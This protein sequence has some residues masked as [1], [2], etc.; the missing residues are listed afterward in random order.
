MR[1]SVAGALLALALSVTAL[2]LSPAGGTPAR[3]KSASPGC[4]AAAVAPA[5]VTVTALAY[6]TA[7]RAY[8]LAAPAVDDPS[9]PLP[10]ILNFHGLTSNAVQQAV[11]SQL[12]DKGPAHGYVVVTPEGS[13]PA[14]FWNILP[15]LPDPDDVGFSEALI[16]TVGEHLCIDPAR[17]YATGISNGAGMSTLLACELPN[18]MAAIAPVAGVNLVRPCPR[19]RPVSVLAFHGQADPIVHYDGGKPAVGAD[20]DTVPVEEAV[21][22]FAHRDGCAPRPRRR[23]IGSEVTRIAYPSCDPGTAVE[24]YAVTNGGHTWPGSI[25]IPRLGNVTQDVNAA[26]LILRFFDTHRGS[27]ARPR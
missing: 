13:G 17:V 1:R 20:I 8:R 7:T 14:H 15:T 26:D 5:G 6:D 23:A 9:K 24:L 12:E 25:D 11:Y 19:G 10:L 18:R 27:P 2:P 22:A 3:G 21:A 16:D 4:A